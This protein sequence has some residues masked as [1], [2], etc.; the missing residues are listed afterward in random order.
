MRSSISKRIVLTPFSFVFTFFSQHEVDSIKLLTAVAARKVKKSKHP[1]LQF[2]IDSSTQLHF[3]W[4]YHFQWVLTQMCFSSIVSL[5]TAQNFIELTT[6]SCPKIC[7]E[8]VFI[9]FQGLS[10]WTFSLKVLS[11]CFISYVSGYSITLV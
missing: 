10:N 9:A 7:F 1:S 11:M 3:I 4:V 6:E 8:S 5:C 2:A